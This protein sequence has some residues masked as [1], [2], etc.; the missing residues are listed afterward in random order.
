M[1]NSYLPFFLPDYSYVIQHNTSPIPSSQRWV[2]FAFLCPSVYVDH[3]IKLSPLSKFLCRFL[4]QVFVCVSWSHA[5]KHF[6]SR[7]FLHL[8]CQILSPVFQEASRVVVLPTQPRVPLLWAWMIPLPV[9][10]K[11]LCPMSFV[12]FVLTR[13]GPSFFHHSQ[14]LLLKQ[15]SLPLHIQFQN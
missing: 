6:H 5:R 14:G 8:P 4:S 3:P 11:L 10:R 9:W 15:P 2:M 7:W 12:G 13:T 1:K